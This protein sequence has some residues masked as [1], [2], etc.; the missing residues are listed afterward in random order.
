MKNGTAGSGSEEKREYTSPLKADYHSKYDDEPRRDL[1]QLITVLPERVLEIGCGSGATG[2]ALKQKFYG[3][4]YTGLESEENIAHIARTRLDKVLTADIEKV[5]LHACGLS[6]GYFDL[7]ICGDVLEHLYDPWKTLSHLHAYLKPKGAILASIPNVQ[8]I[9]NIFNL[10]NGHWTYK[11]DGLLDAT[12][13]RFFTLQEI[14]KMFS[15]TGYRLTQCKGAMDPKLQSETWPHNFDFG[16]FELKNVTRREAF[17]FSILQ[18][19]IMAQK[20]VS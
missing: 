4:E 13:I 9:N 19:L 17:A 6:R 5:Q 18:Y 2:A 7:I 20:V 1:I 3:I 10:L 12:H 16:K 14:V 15:E 8:Y 11:K